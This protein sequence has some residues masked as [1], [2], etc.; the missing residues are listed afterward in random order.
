MKQAIRSTTKW[1]LMSLALH[2]VIVVMA[3]SV[4]V[5]VEITE[6][7]RDFVPLVSPG[8]CSGRLPLIEFDDGPMARL[9]KENHG[10]SLDECGE[11]KTGCQLE[12][13]NFV[14]YF[15]AEQNRM[16]DNLLWSHIAEQS[17]VESRNGRHRSAGNAIAI[18]KDD[19]PEFADIDATDGQ[20]REARSSDL[21][22]A[23]SPFDAAVAH[24]K[25][26]PEPQS[27]PCNSPDCL[28]K[29][30]CLICK[31]RLHTGNWSPGCC[32]QKSMF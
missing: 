2:G 19:P 15:T 30:S 24:W 27:G 11:R 20:T 8:F 9:W 18:I 12:N 29:S 5:V 10:A 4:T 32:C 3:A 14:D 6:E 22:W 26:F 7:E 16:E 17:G 25:S 21:F 23:D 28:C 1:C 31:K 13:G